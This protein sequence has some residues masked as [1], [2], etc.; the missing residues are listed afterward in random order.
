VILGDLLAVGTVHR[1]FV[2]DVDG[3]GR[4]LRE[5]EL[6]EHDEE[7]EDGLHGKDG[8]D[9]LGIAAG[10]GDTRLELG[11]PAE[12]GA[13]P[14]DAVAE[15]RAVCFRAV[16]PAAVHGGVEIRDG[17]GRRVEHEFVLGVRE[18]VG[19]EM[20][21]AGCKVLGWYVGASSEERA[22]E[23]LAGAA[24]EDAP[25][26]DA[27]D[28]TCIELFLGEDGVRGGCFGIQKGESVC[29]KR[30]GNLREGVSPKP[31]AETRPEFGC[32]KTH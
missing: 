27:E 8:G 21:A 18:E 7:A 30:R 14:L 24:S 5:A 15:P 22:R 13:A 16:A 4:R 12:G 10:E 25:V 28:P 26:G 6:G 19:A 3:D 9:G 11:A 23:A 20:C 17:A 32:V 29:R 2:V 1:S 31:G